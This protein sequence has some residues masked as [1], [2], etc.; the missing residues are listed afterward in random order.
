MYERILKKYDPTAENLLFILHDIQDSEPQQYITEQ[1]IREVT[2]YLNVSP[3]QIYS[4]IT[5]YSLY[6]VVPR[7]KYIIRVCDSPPCHLMGSVSIVDELMDIL[8]IEVGET[9]DDGLFTLEITSCLGVCGVAPAL[10]I[11]KELYGNL[12]P[13]KIRTVLDGYRKNKQPAQ[14]VVE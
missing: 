10:M 3:S 13:S 12:T 6:S 8:G 1:A 14:Q 7:G 9:T 4:V 11:N 2:D 5:F